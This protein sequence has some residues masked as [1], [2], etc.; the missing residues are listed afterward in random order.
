MDNLLPTDVA[1]SAG[2]FD[3]E[4]SVGI[5]KFGMDYRV[6]VQFGM[7]DL[8]PLEKMAALWGS[9]PHQVRRKFGETK[10]WHWK[11]YGGNAKF[12]L[13]QM[14]PYLT[15]KK[16]QALLAL[17]FF[18]TVGQR[19]KKSHMTQEVRDLRESL[20]IRMQGLKRREVVNG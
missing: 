14:L 2:L 17:E 6:L 20:R 12:M 4:G 10:V 7:T 11:L 5:Y 8:A 3:G 1:Y 15:N 19:G 16:P 9:R 13:Q 18:E